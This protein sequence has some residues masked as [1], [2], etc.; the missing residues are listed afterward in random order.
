MADGAPLH[1][2]IRV[3]VGLYS[4]PMADT[5]AQPAPDSDEALMLAFAAGNLAAFD[6]L[7]A[8]HRPGLYAFVARQLFGQGVAVDD[9]FQETWLAVTRAR[10]GYRPS[11]KFRTWLFQIARNRAIDLLRQK[12]PLLASEWQR[13]DDGEDPLSALPDEHAQSPEGA[14]DQAHKAA[15]I[16]RALAALPA[17]QREAFLLREHADLPVED[18]ARVMG[19]N[20]ETTRSR[21]RYATG[22]LRAA[23]RGIWP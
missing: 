17:V 8:R 20:V 6:T 21:L 11:A 1:A 4:T 22:K 2:R 15:A 16:T 18:I 13:Q 14:L 23:L 7:Y 5:A 12:R 9:V 19:V 3:G 10:A